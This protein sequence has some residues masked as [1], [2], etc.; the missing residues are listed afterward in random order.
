[1]EAAMFRYAVLNS[2]NKVIE[3]ILYSALLV[4]KPEAYILVD[5]GV[6]IGVGYDYK[7]GVF[8]AP[9]PHVLAVVVIANV[10][11]SP[12]HV[13]RAQIAPDFSAIKLPVGAK[14]TI[15]A[16]LQ[17]SGQRVPGFAAEFAMPLRSTDGLMRYLDVRFADG[18]TTFS[19]LMSDS[20]R[21]E[22]TQELIN[23]NLPPE[24]HMQFAGMVITAVE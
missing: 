1:M 5:E 11:V 14:V 3:L 10:T 17:I 12:E 6:D 8:R 19:A 24:M 7:D 4:P 18:R 16:E 2:A 15:D 13:G 9:D 22:V 20:K 21:W 23:S